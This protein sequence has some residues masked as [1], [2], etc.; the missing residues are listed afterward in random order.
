MPNDYAGKG[1]HGGVIAI[2]PSTGLIDPHRQVIVGNTVLYGATGG[3]F[4]CSKAWLA[5]DLPCE[6]A[7]LRHVCRGT[8]QHCCEY[9][10]RGEVVV[11]W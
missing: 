9:M 2:R 6:T 10:T 11:L 8:G 1:M 5:D 3:H 7:G 4:L